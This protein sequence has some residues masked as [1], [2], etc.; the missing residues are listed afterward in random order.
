VGSVVAGES[1]WTIAPAPATMALVK[2]GRLR[3]IAHSLPRR[4]GLF[5]ELPA[6]AETLP[7]YDYSGWAGLLGPK[8][9][10]P[11]QVER[12]RAA[13]AQHVA[14]AA[15]R[16]RHNRNAGLRRGLEG[17]AAERAQPRGAAESALGEND[18]RAAAPRNVGELARGLRALRHVDA[19][20]ELRAEALQQR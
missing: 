7:G 13:L 9:I 10:P 14:H 3:A 18:E 1:Q 8:V 16:D 5:G 12:L 11:A 4:S 17:A 19:L 2:G 6:V 20:D 15:Q